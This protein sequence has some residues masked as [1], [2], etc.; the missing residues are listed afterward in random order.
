MNQYPSTIVPGRRIFYLRFQVNNPP[1]FIVDTRTFIDG[2][3]SFVVDTGAFIDDDGWG[4]YKGYIF[5]GDDGCFLDNGDT[6][7]EDVRS[8]LVE[9]YSFD[10]YVVIFCP[11][12]DTFLFKF[13]KTFAKIRSGFAKIRYV[14]AKI[15]F[16]VA[17]IEYG[18]CQNPLRV[19]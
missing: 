7:E 1:T 4:D 19:C 6:F 11:N 15:R 2:I 16:G 9:K 3:C 12:E 13:S 10:V 14:G 8:F 17:K 5:D 18:W